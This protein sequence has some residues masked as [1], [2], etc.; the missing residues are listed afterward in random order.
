MTPAQLKL[1][2]REWAAVRRANPQAVRDEITVAA[3]G[4]RVSSL[5]LSNAEFDQV[6]AAF[7][8]VSRPA[9]LGAQVRAQRQERDRWLWRLGWVVQCL[10][11]YVEDPAAYVISISAGKLRAGADGAWD[12]DALDDRP[13]VRVVKGVPQESPSEIAQLLMTL[14]ARLHDYRREAGES[15][16][17]MATRA[18]ARCY[19]ARCKRSRVGR[20]VNPPQARGRRPAPVAA[21]VAETETEGNPF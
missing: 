11:L 12:L 2:W 16:H 1:Y 18:G 15:I 3:L 6:L 5:A 13:R 20:V 9:D 4:R 7:R 14:T 19:C 17:M 8:A 21:A 10:G